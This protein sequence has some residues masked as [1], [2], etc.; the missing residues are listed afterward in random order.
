MTVVL[1]AP[2]G[3]DK[4]HNL[5]RIDVEADVFQDGLPSEL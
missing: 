5:S 3:P 4:G 1:P 2:V